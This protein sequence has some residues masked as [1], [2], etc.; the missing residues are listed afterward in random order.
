MDLTFHQDDDSGEETVL[1]SGCVSIRC[2]QGVMGQ[3]LR[4]L[5]LV[6]HKSL[7]EGRFAAMTK[8]DLMNFC[9]SVHSNQTC[10]ADVCDGLI[11]WK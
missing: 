8:N 2:V 3:Q 1:V 6:T 10:R 4:F 7:M 9:Q 11:N 5:T